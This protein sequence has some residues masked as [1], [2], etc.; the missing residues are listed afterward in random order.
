MNLTIT[1]IKLIVEA[2]VPFHGLVIKSIVICY[3]RSKGWGGG[4]ENGRGRITR[5]RGGEG[6]REGEGK[7]DEEKEG[8]GPGGGGG[9]K[10]RER[11]RMGGERSSLQIKAELFTGKGTN[12]LPSILEALQWNAHIE[13][14]SRMSFSLVR[15]PRLRQEV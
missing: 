4:G 15:T 11:R 1:L 8:E 13:S 6:K 3:K 9:V 10:W 7:E 12:R 14:V 2:E 5:R